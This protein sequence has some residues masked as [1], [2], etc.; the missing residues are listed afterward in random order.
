[1]QRMTLVLVAP[2]G[3]PPLAAAPGAFVEGGSAGAAGVAPGW[4]GARRRP[5][6]GGPSFATAAPRSI[7]THPDWPRPL[8][9]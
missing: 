8:T 1:M 5:R 7:C 6:G 3:A 9:L 2:V 4:P